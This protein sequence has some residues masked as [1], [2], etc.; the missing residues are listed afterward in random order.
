MNTVMIVPQSAELGMLRS[1]ARDAVAQACRAGESDYQ[2]HGWHIHAWVWPSRAGRLAH[3]EVCYRHELL[4]Q[5][6]CLID[7]ARANPTILKH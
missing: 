1:L 7:S 2:F 6:T 3:W 5:G 4:E